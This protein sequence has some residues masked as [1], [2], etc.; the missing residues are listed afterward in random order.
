[1]GMIVLYNFKAMFHIIIGINILTH[2]PISYRILKLFELDEADIRKRKEPI[3]NL[4]KLLLGLFLSIN[5]ALLN[6]CAP[7][8]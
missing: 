4:Q 7:T 5:L 2:P 6:G 1:V 3:M 8:T